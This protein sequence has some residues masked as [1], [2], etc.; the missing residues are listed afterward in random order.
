MEPNKRMFL[1][2]ACERLSGIFLPLALWT[3]NLS[4]PTVLGFNFSGKNPTVPLRP[5]STHSHFLC[6]MHSVY[7]SAFVCF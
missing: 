5:G 4:W 1:K 7:V 2:Q 3:V 6:V